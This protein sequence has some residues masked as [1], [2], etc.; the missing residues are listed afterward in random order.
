[1]L[2]REHALLLCEPVDYEELSHAEQEEYAERANASERVVAA[3]LNEWRIGRIGLPPSPEQDRLM[4]M[5]LSDWLS[6]PGGSE[7]RPSDLMR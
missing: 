2:L 6:P 5:K 7:C 1:M 3:Q 4:A